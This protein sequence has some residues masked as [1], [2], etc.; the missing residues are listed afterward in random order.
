MNEHDM[1][2]LVQ[3]L[4]TGSPVELVIDEKSEYVKAGCA[5]LVLVYRSW[6]GESGSERDIRVLRR[7]AQYLA[8]HGYG[9]GIAKILAEFLWKCDRDALRWIITTYDKYVTDDR[10]MVAWVTAL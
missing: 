9:G 5:I 10:A 8:M 6:V 1:N 7:Y 3:C 2:M 4:K